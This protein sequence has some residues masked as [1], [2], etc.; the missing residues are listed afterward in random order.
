MRPSA[1]PP[2]VLAILVVVAHVGALATPCV[3]GIARPLASHET[4]AAHAPS[5]E[6]P[7]AHCAEHAAPAPVHA[8]AP[9]PCGCDDA[10]VPG[11]AEGRLGNALVEAPPRVAPR[12]V[13][14]RFRATRGVLPRAPLPALDPVPI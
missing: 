4:Q 8:S 11:K 5:A 2:Q 7:G 13:S 10:S 6:A 9:C 12:P 14:R 1:R 3:A